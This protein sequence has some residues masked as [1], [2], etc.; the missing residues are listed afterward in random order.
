MRSLQCPALLGNWGNQ[1]ATPAL[2]LVVAT[3][4]APKIQDFSVTPRRVCAGDTVAVSW[5][6]SGSVTLVTN[7]RLVLPA[8]LA[9][10]GS[11]H[12]AVQDTTS[13]MVVA[14]RGSKADSARQ[15][16]AVL[17]PANEKVLAFRMKPLGDTALTAADSAPAGQWDDVLVIETVRSLAGRALHVEHGGR[18]TELAADSTASEALRGL[19][20][21]G[22]WTITAPLVGEEKIND[23]AHRWPAH[24]H[25][26]LQLTCAH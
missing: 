13:F 19:S 25:L 18:S 20:V 17:S 23:P 14:S 26:G 7:P 12:V 3:A 1:F 22:A 4:C 9:T 6:A 24:L 8:H 5:R 21:Q 11:L 2:L 15:D 16:V 10:S